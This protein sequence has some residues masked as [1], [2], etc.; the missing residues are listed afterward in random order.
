[1]QVQIQQSRPPYARFE[2]RA[3]E[4]RDASLAAKRL[5][6]KPVD[7]ALITPSGSR[8]VHEKIV[9]EWLEKLRGDVDQE[10]FPAAWLDHYQNQYAHWKKGQE[11]PL[12]GTD[13]RN[14]AVVGASRAVNLVSMGFRTV[15]D[16]ADATEEGIARMGMDGRSLR[17]QA[18]Q[19][20]SNMTG[21]AVEAK[22]EA[23]AA[24]AKIEELQKQVDALLAAKATEQAAKTPQKV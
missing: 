13:I 8:D 4:D 10:R 14:W 11:A 17:D 1:M 21:T 2:T 5:M 19:W 22:A 23:A 12:I 20:V 24:N 18:R 16:I 6:T 9:E 15:E 3:V 7:Y